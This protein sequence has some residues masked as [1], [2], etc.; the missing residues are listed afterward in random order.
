MCV[1]ANVA[2]IGHRFGGAKVHKKGQIPIPLNVYHNY[3]QKG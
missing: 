1:K 2:A 3:E